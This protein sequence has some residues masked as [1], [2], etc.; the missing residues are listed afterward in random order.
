MQNYVGI[1]W[2]FSIDRI[3][4]GGGKIENEGN[5]YKLFTYL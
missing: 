2:N 3:G 5:S 4:S 1:K